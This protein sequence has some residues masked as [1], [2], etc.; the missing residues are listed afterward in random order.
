MNRRDVLRVGLL[1]TLGMGVAPGLTGCG[2]TPSRADKSKGGAVG[3]GEVAMSQ[4]ARTAADASALPAAVDVVHAFGTD[5][6]RRLAARP[7]NVVCSP[8]SVAVALAMTRNGARGSTATEMDR[9]L[10]A[11]R[12]AELNSGFNALA[13]HLDSRAGERRRA[14][15]SAAKLSL[16]AANSL[17]GQQEVRWEQTFLDALARSYG[18]GLRMVDYAA[19]AEGA[20]R[21]INTWTGQRTAGRIPQLVPA[22]VLDR[23][24]R[25]VLVN[26]IYLKAPW[27][28]PFTKAQTQRADFTLGDGSRVKV[29]MMRRLVKSARHA[30]GPGW[31]AVDLRYAGSQLAMAVVLPDQGHLASVQRGLDGAALGRLLA[32]F[33]PGGVA[34]SLPRWTF[35]TQAGLGEL[36]GALGMPTAFTEQAD[37]AGMTTQEKL[38]ISAVLHE[39]FIAV[40]EEGTEAAAATAVAAGITSA[41]ASPLR[42]TVDRPFMFVIH[43]VETATPL[44]IGRVDDPTK[45]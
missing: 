26:A 17:W 45:S 7:G 37:F 32:G 40:D 41:P 18:T 42:V 8:Y 27:E 38:L 9:V 39:A 33:G 34:L 36:L 35:R 2:S 30:S 28:E 22:G 11:P 43:D 6:Y 19:D 4:V 25:L 13:L 15:G 29:P 3:T 44:F 12:L 1:A 10:H 31:Q 20:R 5:L 16:A 14:D 24:T 23:Q 21:A